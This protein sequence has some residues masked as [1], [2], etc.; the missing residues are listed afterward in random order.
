DSSTLARLRAA[1]ATPEVVA[2]NDLVVAEKATDASASE[3]AAGE[4]GVEAARQALAAVRELEAY[5]RV[6]APFAGVV[7]ERLVHPGALVGPGD[8]T[9]MLRVVDTRRLRLVVPV[10]E[11]YAAAGTTGGTVPFAVAGFP[12]RTFTG[13]VARLAG[14]V[15]VATRTMPVE[16]DVANADGALTPGSFC[17][18]RWPVRRPAPSLFVPSGSVASTTD[19]TF[20]IRIRDGKAEWVT[21][22]TGMSDGPLVEVFGEL[23]AGDEVA[24]RGTDEIRAGDPVQA[25]QPSPRS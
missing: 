16:L 8:A 2:G 14:A 18:V 20:V 17:Q 10:P 19:R 21:V 24:A 1:S 3:V 25:R 4:Q 7:S 15:D 23:A 5:L 22:R 12:E 9:P 11:A 6:T 13:T